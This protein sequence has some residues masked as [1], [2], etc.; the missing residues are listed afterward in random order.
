MRHYGLHE[1]AFV[2]C[3]LA[4]IVPLEI[5]VGPPYAL[6]VQVGIRRGGSCYPTSD[7]VGLAE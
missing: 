3:V 1:R 7:L 6:V 4:I 2:Y 5:R